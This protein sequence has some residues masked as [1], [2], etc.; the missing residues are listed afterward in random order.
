MRTREE[1]IK[2]TISKLF[3]VYPE[4]GKAIREK[5]YKDLRVGDIVIHFKHEK[6]SDENLI[7][8]MYAIRDF[9]EH[10]E[11]GETLVYYQALYGDYKSYVRPAEMFRSAV[12]KEKYRKIKQEKRMMYLFNHSNEILFF[13]DNLSIES[14]KEYAKSNNIDITKE[15]NF[16]SSMYIVDEESN[17][18]IR[19]RDIKETKDE[20]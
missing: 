12:D 19:I 17:M 14:I 20:V 3:K 15:I 10:T 18:V 13:D 6:D 1:V 7:N 16:N 9:V 4:S 2:K 11:T 8:Y 5:T